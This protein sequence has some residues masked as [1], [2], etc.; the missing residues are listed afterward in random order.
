MLWGLFNLCSCIGTDIVDDFVEPRLSI[1]NKIEVMLAGDSYQFEARY[2]DNT[3][4][5]QPVN[6]N[7][8]SSQPGVLGINENGAALALAPG[9]A[10][11][12]AVFDQLTESFTVEVLDP[13]QVDEDS[14]RMMQ[15]QNGDRTAVLETVSSYQLE[16]TAILRQSTPLLLVLSNDFATTDALPGLY[17]YLTNNTSSIANAL[18]IGAVT[19]FSGSQQY[20]IPTGV[21]LNDYRYV[22]F[23]C[24]PFRVPVGVGEFMP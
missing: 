1:T 5:E 15:S 14:V 24:K 18:E 4:K 23:Y 19:Q 3:G 20:E 6:F 2:F 8:L 16:G 10:T 17:L 21:G 12:T 9:M 11:I 13:A 7:W 22:L